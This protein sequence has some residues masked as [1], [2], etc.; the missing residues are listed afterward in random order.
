[1][2]KEEKTKVL[3]KS[4]GYSGRLISMSKGRYNYNNPDNITVFNS[5]I[6]TKEDGKI[7]Y[8]DLDITL[9]KKILDTLAKKLNTTLYVLTESDGRFEN[10][11]KPLLEDAK[12]VTNGVTFSFRNQELIEEKKDKFVYKKVDKKEDNEST[13]KKAYNKRQFDFDKVSKIPPFKTF[14]SKSKLK[15]PYEKFY[16]WAAKKYGT[17]PQKTA[18][19]ITGIYVIKEDFDVLEAMTEKWMKKVLKITQGYD[20]QKNMGYLSLMISPA[21]FFGQPK[22]AEKGKVYFKKGSLVNLK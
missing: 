15:S 18:L 22:W 6:C 20:L 8:G 4:L 13:Y 17:V 19:G 7:W 3:E 9:E 21:Y 11:K 5:N 1:M 14:D 16:E 12:Y 10:E 2:K